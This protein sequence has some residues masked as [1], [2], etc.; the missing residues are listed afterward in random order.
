MWRETERDTLNQ[1]GYHDLNLMRKTANQYINYEHINVMVRHTVLFV[2][3]LNPIKLSGVLS[4]NLEYDKKKT[5]S[6][7]EDE[8]ILFL[9]FL[10][11]A[12]QIVW[13]GNQKMFTSASL[14][15]SGQ[16]VKDQ[17]IFLLAKWWKER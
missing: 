4:M 7:N 12:Y 5:T 10:R 16:A 14:V 6:G 2:V 15:H 8:R 17:V 3:I 13:S 9:D 11:A 1:G